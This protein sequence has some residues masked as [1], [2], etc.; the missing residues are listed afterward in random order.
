MKNP[1]RPIPR[2]RES[3]IPIPGSWRLYPLKHLAKYPALASVTFAVASMSISTVATLLA[4][5]KFIEAD[6]ADTH[7]QTVRTEVLA[8]KEA[9]AVLDALQAG[10]TSK[11]GVEEVVT[12]RALLG[13]TKN[14]REI[15]VVDD[16]DQVLCAAPSGGILVDSLE[17]T[18][19]IRVVLNKNNYDIQQLKSPTK[20]SQL[21]QY[22][23]FKRGAYSIVM[24]N[25]TVPIRV[26]TKQTVL[27]ESL[28]GKPISVNDGYLTDRRIKFE[29]EQLALSRKQYRG[30][31]WN[32]M[33]YI[34]VTPLTTVGVTVATVL[35]IP[36]AIQKYQNE[37]GMLL[38]GILGI[39]AA[40]YAI[41]K[42]Y[43][44]R[45]D[46]IEHFV[47]LLIR[48]SNL[49]CV[50]Q[51]IIDL[52]TKGVVGC[53]VLVRFKIGKQL[54][55]PENILKYVYEQGLGWY[56]D[57]AVIR[58]AWSELSEHIYKKRVTTAALSVAI[59]VSPD[60]VRHTPI[61]TLFN[62]LKASTPGYENYWHI[63]LEIIEHRYS[64]NLAEHIERLK[65]DGFSFSI[66]DFGTGHSNLNR[67]GTIKPDFLKIDSTFISTI[68]Y[69]DGHTSLIPDIVSIARNV[70]AVSIGEGIE[71]KEQLELLTSLGVDYGQG[72]HVARPMTITAFVEYLKRTPQVDGKKMKARAA[73]T[74]KETSVDDT[75][76]AVREQTSPEPVASTTTPPLE[77]STKDASYIRR[78]NPSIGWGSTR[79]NLSI[80]ENEIVEDSAFAID[81]AMARE[82]YEGT[83]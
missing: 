30:L 5:H 37:I 33:A 8:W 49:V 34:S 13:Q 45:F 31:S 6:V 83:L 74:Y 32:N 64:H 2:E 78:P 81:D 53:E 24:V 69:D 27:I 29:V 25:D 62:P 21:W 4:L 16:E 67:L 22:V 48:P 51:P 56:L 77:P 80:N 59:N 50:Y 3:V 58:K 70:N 44:G 65:K 18:N 72:Y 28:N 12:M 46:S 42:N 1:K 61:T 9:T 73:S 60:N 17:A 55:A 63:N 71:T 57:C 76:I 36:D 54:S 39:G 14:L 38:A 43:L 41:T 35:S 15:T 23:R 52:Q 40:A 20:T 10:N 68:P 75:A 26:F 47:R 82:S 11:C 66:D 19:T 79:R 7:Q